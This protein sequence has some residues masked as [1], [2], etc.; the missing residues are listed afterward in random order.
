MENRLSRRTNRGTPGQNWKSESRSRE[1]EMERLR[2]F[3]FQRLPFFLFLKLASD[4]AERNLQ[5]FG[6]C[7][8]ACRRILRAR[9]IILLRAFVSHGFDLCAVFGRQ[10]VRM[11]EIIFRVNVLGASL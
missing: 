7:I 6:I 10:D 3:R 9:A 2:L 8:E 1:R 4:V 5:S 11:L